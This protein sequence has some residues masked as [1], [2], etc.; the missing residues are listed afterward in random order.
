MVI[1][2]FLESFIRKESLF[3]NKGIIQ[4]SYTPEEIPHREEQINHLAKITQTASCLPL[5]L[6]T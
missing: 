5:F 6:I 1:S 2:E 3:K 4:S